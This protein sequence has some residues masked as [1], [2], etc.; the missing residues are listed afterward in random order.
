VKTWKLILAVLLIFGAGVVTGGMLVRVRIPAAVGADLAAAP[1]KPAPTNTVAD[2]SGV[3]MPGIL[4]AGRQAFT[5]RLKK[6]VSL[7]SE[8]VAEVDRIMDRSRERMLKIWEPI[9]PQAREETRAVRT[10]IYALLDADQKVKFD[11]SFRAKKPREQ[12]SIKPKRGNEAG[13]FG[14]ESAPPAAT[15][16]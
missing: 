10:Q 5:Q 14:K 15:V 3:K 7:T 4:G 8:Q 1:E 12:D 16:R 9:A 2:L 13:A 6:Q 11:E